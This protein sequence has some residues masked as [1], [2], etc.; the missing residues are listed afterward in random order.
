MVNR[1]AEAMAL[2]AEGNRLFSRKDYA[3]AESYYSR[4]SVAVPTVSQTQLTHSP[5][6]SWTRP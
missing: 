1:E 2:K 4:A 5:A 3:G 6:S